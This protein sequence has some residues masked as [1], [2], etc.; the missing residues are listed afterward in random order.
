MTTFCETSKLLK[1][2]ATTPMTASK[3]ERCFSTLKRI[4][5]FL[6]STISN[7]RLGAL[8]VISIESKLV[9]EIKDFS[10]KV[11][12]HF[13]KSKIKRKIPCNL[14]VKNLRTVRNNNVLDWQCV[15]YDC[16]CSK[17]SYLGEFFEKK[18]LHQQR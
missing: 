11:M 13:P 10:E 5:S 1:I 18:E 7:K 15:Q 2:L 16:R 6:R 4:K 9:S 17:M 3:S 14:I 8:A 12:D